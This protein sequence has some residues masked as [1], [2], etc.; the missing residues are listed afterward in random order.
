[1]ARLRGIAER[2]LASADPGV[3][4]EAL[5]TCVEEC[6]RVLSMLNSLMDI[7]EADHGTLRL[8]LA[9]VPLRSVMADAVDLYE[10]TADQKGVRLSIADGPEVVVVADRDRLRQVVANLVDNATKYTP[11]GG[12]VTL[13]A[14]TEGREA[15]MTVTDTGVGIAPA[16]QSRIW[17]R[18]YRADPSRSERGLGLGLSLVRAYVRAHGGEAEVASEP[19]H[20]STFT[21]RVP[22]AGP[23]TGSRLPASGAWH[24]TRL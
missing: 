5:A 3:Q 20:G 21:I 12:R 17:Q 23:A 19:G 7:A 1:M 11:A 2:G 14:R 18:L 9:E 8:A 10:D 6:D 16:D 22:L 24:L 4:R 15:V 13:A